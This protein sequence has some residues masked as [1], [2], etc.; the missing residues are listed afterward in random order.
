MDVFDIPG[1]LVEYT[2]RAS[3]FA[4]EWW[5]VVAV[6]VTVT[7]SPLSDNVPGRQL[8]DS[9]PPLLNVPLAE[10]GTR[11]AVVVS[12]RPTKAKQAAVKF[13]A[14]L[15]G[16]AFDSERPLPEAGGQWATVVSVP[17]SGV[18]SRRWSWLVGRRDDRMFAFQH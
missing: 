5:C 16:P 1:L 12:P 10:A 18:T 7:T 14:R 4:A 15:S 2:N 11:W 17:R 8:C 3:H 9:T 6:A 13:P